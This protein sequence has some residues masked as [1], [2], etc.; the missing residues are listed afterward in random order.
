LKSEEYYEFD[1]VAPENDLSGEEMMVDEEEGNPPFRGAFL[2]L[3]LFSLLLFTRPTDFI[4]ALAPFR[5]VMVVGLLSIISFIFGLTKQPGT[6]HSPPKEVHLMLFFL[7]FILISVP[8]S[9]WPGGSVREIGDTISKI[10]IIFFLLVFVLNSVERVRWLFFVLVT[11]GALMEFVTFYLEKSGVGRIV[12]GRLML[13][14]LA[15]DP[16]DRALVFVFLLPMALGLMLEARS[17]FWKIYYGAIALVLVE[18]ILHTLSRGGI[19]GLFA[20]G[21]W[22]CIRAFPDR[23]LLVILLVV[24]ALIGFSLVSERVYYR[25]VSIFNPEY[26]ETGSRGA[27]IILLKQGI[28]IMLNNPVVGVGIGNF[29]VA[30]GKTSQRSGQWFNP[31]NSLIQVGAENGIPA[32]IVYLWMYIVMFKNYRRIQRQFDATSVNPSLGEL[33]RGLEISL[34]GFFVCSFF[35]SQ[36]YT[37]YFYYLVGLSG[38]FRRIVWQEETENPEFFDSGQEEGEEDH[39]QLQPEPE[40]F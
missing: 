28:E 34:V 18:G 32:L 40:Y 17:N 12:A 14:G 20:V 19:L 24:V 16:N 11:S 27:R 2:M 4:Y 36:A 39:G 6:L 21:G 7:V 38:A 35:L 8:F 31:H 29:T 5:L 25:A 26:D 9:L 1:D 13:P 37:W 33:A 30:Q 3:L 23:K 10:Y 22:F 15:G